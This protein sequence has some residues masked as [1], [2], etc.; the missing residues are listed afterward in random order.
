MEPQSINQSRR[1]TNS[2]QIIIT[3]TGR[4]IETHEERYISSNRERKGYKQ[5]Q[6]EW[7]ILKA[8]SKIFSGERKRAW[9]NKCI[10]TKIWDSLT[11]LNWKSDIDKTINKTKCSFLSLQSKNWV[12]KSEI[13]QNVFTTCF[14]IINS[15]YPIFQQLLY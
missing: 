14:S 7:D 10:E 6:A 3:A 4:R 5:R 2:S 8:E 15:F 13:V 12:D 11:I 9:K 1:Q